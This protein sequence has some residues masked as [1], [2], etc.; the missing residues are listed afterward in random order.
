MSAYLMGVISAA[1]L[2]SLILAVGGEGPGKG[3]RRL[4][5]SLFL[6]LA[7]FRPLGA[8]ELPEFDLD[9]FRDAAQEA[10]GEGTAQA[11]EARSDIIS[12]ACEAYILNKAA[13]LG[14][15]PQVRVTL[16][17]EGLPTAVSLTGSASPSERE[18]LSGWIAR[19]LGLGKEA[20]TWNV[21][22]QSSE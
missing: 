5:G 2:V 6:A 17:E 19:D 20:V 14:L 4:I 11:A 7:V 21:L 22:Y 9:L 8:M 18:A 3:T 10:V 15:E 12:E 16:N 13:E 1:F